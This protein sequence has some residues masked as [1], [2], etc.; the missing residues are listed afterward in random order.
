MS[1]KFGLDRGQPIDRYYIERFLEAR[2][3]LI[4]GRV[5]EVGDATYTTRFGG[6]AVTASD[7]LHLTGEAAEATIVA[8][9][10]SGAGIP[11][12]AFDCIV[13]TQTLPFIYD[14]PAA[15]ANL[16]AALRPTGAVLLTVPGIS[17]ISRFDM[18]RWGDFWRFTDASLTRLLTERFDEVDVESFGNVGAACALLQGLASEEVGSRVLD[19]RDPDYQ[20]VLVAVA[21]GPR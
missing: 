18:E 7:V 21:R 10:A 14:L 4:R 5:L 6:A 11:R 15:M 3:S 1:T 19:V 13:I 20:V 9:L 12:Q 17:Q 16:A 2:E 8:D